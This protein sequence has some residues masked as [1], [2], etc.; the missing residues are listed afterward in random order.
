MRVSEILTE[1]VEQFLEL[2]PAVE[3][4]LADTDNP[5]GVTK[6]DVGLGNVTNDLQA[7]DADF[8]SHKNAAELDHADGS[9]KAAK[10]ADGAVQTKK[11]ADSAVTAEKLAEGAV[12]STALAGGAVTAEKIENGAVGTVAIKSG[13]VIESTLHPSLRSSIQNKV[14][15]VEGMG[16]SQNNFSD[17]QKEKLDAI[18]V[19]DGS[20]VEV[21]MNRLVERNKPFT[22]CK[23]GMT[24]VD[25]GETTLCT[26]IAELYSVESDLPR[27]QLWVAYKSTS[28]IYKVFVRGESTYSSANYVGREKTECY[29]YASPYVYFPEAEDTALKIYRVSKGTPT[30]DLWMSAT[31]SF[32]KTGGWIQHIF[33]DTQGVTLLYYGD[34]SGTSAKMYLER[35]DTN[36]NSKWCRIFTIIGKQSSYIN[37]TTNDTLFN[38]IY[39]KAVIGAD[40]KLY[41]APVMASSSK[42]STESS[43]TSLNCSIARINSSGQIDKKYYPYTSA[44]DIFVSQDI[45]LMGEYLYAFNRSRIWRYA[46]EGDGVGASQWYFDNTNYLLRGMTPNYDGQV[47]LMT[48]TTDGSN[49]LIMT[50]ANID[51]TVDTS[52]GTGVLIKEIQPEKYDI[53]RYTIR[54]FE[55]LRMPE[56]TTTITSRLFIPSDIYEAI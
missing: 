24:Y 12:T 8:R 51:R 2:A 27:G 49:V 42:L 4:H 29:G 30:P 19:V 32:S 25:K 9:V 36:G 16:L 44:G 56:G 13:S 5:H 43:A 46:L 45:A 6:E 35:F 47:H 54:G 22:F 48:K 34:L 17:E 15:K 52:Y 3:S 38:R 31:L 26:D 33:V 41:V 10:L 20:G 28:G 7:K 53:A 55:A 14:D 40:G 39:R 1:G 50:R 37:N 11:I 21:D 23:T 18:T